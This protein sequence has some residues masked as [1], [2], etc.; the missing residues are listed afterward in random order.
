MRRDV[1]DDISG[2]VDQVPLL[3]A[4]ALGLITAISP[5]TL[6]A[7][8]SGAA[9]VCRNMK[10]PQYALLVGILL[11]SGR[12]I[13]FVVLGSIMIAAGHTLGE[14]ALF[15]QNVGTILLGCVLFVIGIVFLDVITVNI[16]MGGG[17][18]AK[19]ME[20]TQAFGLLGALFLG[21]L[22]GFAFCPYSAL[23]FFGMLIPLA[24]QVSE[25]YLLPV[26]FGIGVNVPVLVFTGMVYVGSRR[27][28][29]VMQKISESWTIVGKILGVI[30]ISAS[31]YYLGPYVA[32]KIGVSL[33]WL[34][35]LVGVVLI[36]VVSYQWWKD[37]S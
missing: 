36:G 18:I 16:D 13:T 1:M 27:A 12:I 11:S 26:L 29:P 9:F 31:L 7:T 14:I 35:Y 15:S 24:V 25:G 37:S 34:P 21:I 28:K 19:M 2:F 32:L 30:L 17:F 3:T 10:T 8:I 4:L 22:F 20:K 5:C 23:L 6:A 33:D